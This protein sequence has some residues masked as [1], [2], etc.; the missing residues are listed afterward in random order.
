LIS[1]THTPTPP[2]AEKMAMTSI[3]SADD[4]KKALNAF[5]GKLLNS[6]CIYQ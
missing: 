5:A 3:L 4:I 1:Y 2:S 6:R